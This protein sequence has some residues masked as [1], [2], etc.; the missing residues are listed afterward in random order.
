[1]RYS[2]DTH[3]TVTVMVAALPNGRHLE[4][5][6]SDEEVTALMEMDQTKSEGSKQYEEVPHP[7]VAES[8]T[9]SSQQPEVQQAPPSDEDF[10]EDTGARSI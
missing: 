8:V 2:F 3:M 5:E 10:D 1:M 7:R 4:F 6:V 9:S